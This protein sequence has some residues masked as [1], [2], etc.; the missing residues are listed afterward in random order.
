MV[1]CKASWR[2]KLGRRGG[3]TFN[4]G[5]SAADGPD[6]ESGEVGRFRFYLVIVH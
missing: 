1:Y 6:I 4:G 2:G 5:Q 3:A